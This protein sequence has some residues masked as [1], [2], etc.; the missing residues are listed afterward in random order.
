MPAATA[1]SP[2]PGTSTARRPTN[3]L[4]RASSSSFLP[5]QPRR[6]PL[7]GGAVAAS[8]CPGRRVACCKAAGP[9]AADHVGDVEE[10]TWDEVVLGCETAVLV[11]FW[12]PWCGPC[13]LMHPIIA[14]LAKAYA[15]RLRCLRVNTDENQEVATRYGIRSIPTILIFKDGERKETVI[16]A[17]ADTALAATVD[18][19]L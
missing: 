4:H 6:R 2:S 7:T 13:R 10:Q 3:P 5:P 16:G 12:A 19:F 18:R 17:I 14:D 11:E 15:G 8:A 9:S 1:T